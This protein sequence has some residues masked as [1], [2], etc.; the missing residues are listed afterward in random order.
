MEDLCER[1]PLFCKFVFSNLDDK[2]LTKCTEASRR[3]KESLDKERLLW[4]RIIKRKSIHF[5]EH[6][7]LWKKAVE[8]TPVKIL[9]NLAV[10]IDQFFNWTS[11]EY[12]VPSSLD[13]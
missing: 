6:S 1:I 11:S 13:I 8:K 12:K 9:K 2:S 10:A 4:L 3:L 7:K 5:N